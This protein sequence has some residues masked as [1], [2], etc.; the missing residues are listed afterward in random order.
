MG[1]DPRLGRTGRAL[2]RLEGQ[3]QAQGGRELVGKGKLRQCIPRV[4]QEEITVPCDANILL[5]SRDGS[6]PLLHSARLGGL[7]LD[8]CWE[9]RTGSEKP[10]GLG[11]GSQVER[12]MYKIDRNRSLGSRGT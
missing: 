6:K 8:G 1:Q 10:W 5:P 12:L 4:H 3:K 9:E 7:L 2:T 11:I